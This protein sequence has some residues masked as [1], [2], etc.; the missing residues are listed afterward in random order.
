MNISK[1]DV[2]L[3]L[4]LPD[5]QEDEEHLTQLLGHHWCVD[6]SPSTARAPV[7]P[8]TQSSVIAYCKG[9]QRGTKGD[10]RADLTYFIA[11]QLSQIIM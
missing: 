3:E 2:T 11:F 10:K 6:D 9:V 1:N 4:E 7:A 8:L 5:Q